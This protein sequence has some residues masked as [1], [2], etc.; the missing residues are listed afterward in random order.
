MVRAPS[1]CACGTRCGRFKPLQVAGAR[2]QYAGLDV[3]I[4]A[5]IEAGRALIVPSSQRATAL[6]YAW[7]RRQQG[8]GIAVWKTP[9][10]LTWEAWLAQQ[11]RS[12]SLQGRVAGGLQLL[13]PAQE[14]ALWESALRQ[15]AGD[16]AEALR[17]H[18]P[19]LMR[20]ASLASQSLLALHK[21]ASTEE[22]MLLVAALRLVREQCRVRGMLSL[23]L[24][25][26]DDLIF[27][28]DSP[29]PLIVGQSGLTPL[30]QRLQ[31]TCWSREPLLAAAVTGTTAAVLR[32]AAHPDAEIIACARWCRELLQEDGNRR[33]LVV[34]CRQDPGAHTQGALLWRALAGNANASDEQHRKLLAVEGGE[35]LQH[36]ALTGDALAALSLMQ[37]AIESRVVLQLVRSPYFDF[38]TAGECAALQSR[39]GA[40]GLARWQLPALRQALGSVSQQVPAA[41]RLLGW[42]EGTQQLLSES[43]RGATGWAE[44][45]S[46]CLGAAG[47]P[48]GATRDSRDVQRLARWGELLDEFAGLDAALEPMD[49]RAAVR[50]LRR[51]AQESVHQ[52]ATG[53]AAITL[54]TQMHDP[55]VHYDGIWV[56]GMAESRWPLP[57]RPDPYIPLFEQR[58]C[59]WPQ[60]GVTQR[61]RAAHWLQDRWQRSADE[62]VLSYAQQEA[63]VLHRP[64]ALA[65]SGA[66]WIDIEAAAAVPT[67]FVAVAGFDREMPPVT[68]HE[69]LQPLRGGVNRL[70]LQQECPFHA[71]AR[72]RLRAEP[73]MELTDGV[74][75]KLRGMLL[76][77]LLE[78][79]WNEL[80]EQQ[81]LMELSRDD[82]VA[83]FC[84]HWD[85]AVRANA[86][87]GVSWLAPAVLA[88]ERQR[89]ERLVGRVLDLDRERAPFAVHLHEHELVWNSGAAQFN[90]RIDR[91]DRTAAGEYL[92]VDYKSGDAG[93][94]RLQEG[95]ARPLQLAVYVAALAQHGMNAGGALLLSLKPAKLEYAGVTGSGE[96]LPGRVKTVDDWSLV[97]QAWENELQSLVTQHLAG[98][99]TLAT[100]TE[101]CR[102]CHLPAFC[103]RRGAADAALEEGTADE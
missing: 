9:V 29:A 59:D 46:S 21:S 75:A 4:V 68:H 52:V 28:G 67:P 98:I 48:A 79:I 58:R 32:R 93:T 96:P 77:S 41:G 88:R 56:M 27:L 70:R 15:L 81:R 95:E 102:H 64:S 71:Q 12:A 20:A 18:V 85:A 7:A 8:L 89:A 40:W 50:V 101:A 37:D 42:L 3:S 36:Q 84:R 103:R 2:T 43:M 6:R 91:V 78:G 33:L 10:V 39:I 13:V 31:E 38:G 55:V 73:P 54:T 22:E 82:E 69:M 11:W 24:A 92:V 47:F 23:T 14:R 19:A 97:R 45:F 86:A 25:S 16:D 83:L 65:T 51:L 62:L 53:D 5:A 60:A 44:A 1:R 100:S 35:P 34:S 61:L 63:D 66:T 90:M 76:H 87:A 49:A 17:S 80:R 30:Q 94:I 99:A 57:P 74:P 72:W 26:P